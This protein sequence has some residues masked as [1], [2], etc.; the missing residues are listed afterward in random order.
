MF[1]IDSVSAAEAQFPRKVWTRKDV[2]RIDP[3][4][5][6]TLELV[7]G[8]LIDQMGKRPPHVYWTDEIRDWLQEQFGS[9]F[10]RSEHPIDVSPEDNPTNEPE[11]DLAVTV[12]S[13]RETR[14]ANPHLEIFVS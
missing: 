10:V 8:E 9:E 1:T 4:L 14:A 5:A 2:E 3:I 11:P 13:R 6:E 7:N 12:K